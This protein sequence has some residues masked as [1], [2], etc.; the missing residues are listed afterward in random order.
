MFAIYTPNGRWF[1]GPLEALHQ[2]EKSQFVN[3]T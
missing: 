1:S 2:V 3:H